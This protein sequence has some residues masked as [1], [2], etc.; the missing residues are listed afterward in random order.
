MHSEAEERHSL[1]RR[2][3]WDLRRVSDVFVATRS[4]SERSR[5]LDLGA[6]WAGSYDQRPTEPLDAAITFAPAG[7]VVVAALRAIDRG[8]TVAINAIHLD[9][10]PE[11]PY[12]LLWGERTLRS[13]ANVTRADVADVLDLAVRIP[14]ETHTESHSLAAANEALARLGAGQVRGAAVLR[15]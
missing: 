1:A 12:E 13:V 11:F 14:I 10:I 8:A 7:E 2:L 15:C 5:A 9:R 3:T 4:K 6:A